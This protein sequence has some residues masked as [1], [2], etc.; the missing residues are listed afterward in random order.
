MKRDDRMTLR[1]PGDMKTMAQVVAAY[2]SRSTADVVRLALDKY[3]ADNGYYDPS[4][5]TRLAIR[6]D[7]P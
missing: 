6:K 3:F 4:F 2:E 7:T 1:L 5:I